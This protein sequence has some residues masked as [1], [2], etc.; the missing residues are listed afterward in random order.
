MPVRRNAP[1]S[2]STPPTWRG[3]EY[4]RRRGTGCS[5]ARQVAQR[6]NPARQAAG[7]APRAAWQGRLGVTGACTAGGI[8]PASEVSV[9]WW[10]G[11]QPWR[12]AP[13][14][15]WAGVGCYVGRCRSVNVV[16]WRHGFQIFVHQRATCARRVMTT[17]TVAPWLE[18]AACR[19]R[20]LS[21]WFPARRQRFVIEVARAVCRSCP[22]RAECLAEALELEDDSHRHGIRGGLTAAER[23]A[24]A[25]GSQRPH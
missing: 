21:W 15:G 1:R 3:S 7:T 18:A 23:R 11:R 24:L 20:P 2:S 5:K 13:V 25:H 8:A 19:G 4:R 16:P 6:A 17:L 22:V 9:V 12:L 10:T 14:V